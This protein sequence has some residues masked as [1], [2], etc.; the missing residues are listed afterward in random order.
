MICIVDK[1]NKIIEIKQSHY[2]K[3]DNERPC[4]LWSKVGEIYTEQEPLEYSRNRYLKMAG[5]D[6]A[7]KRD[8]VRKIKTSDGNTYGF[9]CASEDIVNF[10]ASWQAAKTDG[11]T[12][13]KVWLDDKTKSLVMLTVADFE[14][15]FNAVRQ[16]QYDAYA[17]YND[18]AQKIKAAQSV[19][20]MEQTLGG[21]D[22]G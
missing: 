17:W 1:N 19:Q 6:F 4:Y 15:V 18:V 10:M 12:M 11:K 20:D 21:A 8:A 14:S 22:I 9:D 13:Y 2:L 3:N 7:Q 5:A 16:S